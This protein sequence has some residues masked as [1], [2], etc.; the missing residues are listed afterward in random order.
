M[1][2]SAKDIRKHGYELMD[3]IKQSLFVVGKRD[4]R[5]ILKLHWMLFDLYKWASFSNNIEGQK[6]LC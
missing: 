6:Y 5:Q 3:N 4:K 1:N 2:H